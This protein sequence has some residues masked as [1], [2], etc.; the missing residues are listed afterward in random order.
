MISS[1]PSVRSAHSTRSPFRKMPFRLRS[2]S[3][4]RR[5]P[6]GRRARGGATRSGRR[7]G[8]R[9]SGCGRSCVHSRVSGSTETLIAVPEGQELARAPDRRGPA[10]ASPGPR[11]RAGRRRPSCP[12]RRTSTRARSGCSP[13]FGH[14]GIS[15]SACSATWKPHVSQRNEP[16]PARVPVWICLHNNLLLS[17]ACPVS[18]WAHPCRPPFPP[19]RRE[20]NLSTCEVLYYKRT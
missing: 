16:A 18:A 11:R 3:T 14:S 4:A 12:A 15:S 1:S 8:C 5:R 20:E 7:G 9:R 13:Q 17:V 2:S 6:G 19:S 10:S